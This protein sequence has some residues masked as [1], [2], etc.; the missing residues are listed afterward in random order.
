M[1]IRFRRGIFVERS[2]RSAHPEPFPE[3][4]DTRQSAGSLPCD[5]ACDRKE[6]GHGASFRTLPDVPFNSRLRSA[7]SK[8][9]KVGSPGPW[10][11]VAP[12]QQTSR[13]GL[14]QACMNADRLMTR[15]LFL[16]VRSFP[17]RIAD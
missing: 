7:H 6:R 12:H 17:A 10:A 15:M 5:R 1:H 3:I 8:T 4:P 2:A 14:L 9:A 16:Q 13:A 11:A